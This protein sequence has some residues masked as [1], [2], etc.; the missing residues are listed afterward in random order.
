MASLRLLPARHV[1]RILR[2][3]GFDQIRQRGSHIVMQRRGEGGTRTAIVPNQREI[4][5][6]TLKSIIR[7]SGLTEEDFQR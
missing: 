6:G 3:H 1:C 2:D 7:Q 4:P 5:H